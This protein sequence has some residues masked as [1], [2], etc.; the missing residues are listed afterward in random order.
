MYTVYI[1]ISPSDK[2]YVG[3]TSRKLNFRINEHYSASKN[4]D[5]TFYRA[6][7]KYKKDIVWFSLT[8]CSLLSEAKELEQFYIKKYK[9]LRTENGYN[10]T[11]GGNYPPLSIF[12]EENRKKVSERF[13][14]YFS[15]P[16]NREANRKRLL[17][18]IPWNKGKTNYLSDKSKKLMSES[19]KGKCTGVNNHNYGK[20]GFM[21]GKKFTEEHKKK[22]S[23]ALKGNSSYLKNGKHVRCR[24]VI[25]TETNEIFESSKAVKERYG[26]VNIS[27]ALIAGSKCAGY[28]WK[29]LDKLGE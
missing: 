4:K 20:P 2:K 14:K 5:F 29:Y 26:R 3:I 12:S 24:E 10:S 27:R 16:E 23:L 15:N 25:C 18:H 6:L 28:H 1:A 7:R 9:S 21:L 11:E 13:K 8:T 22:I 17:G 19:R